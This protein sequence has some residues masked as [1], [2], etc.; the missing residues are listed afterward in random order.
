MQKSKN[1][2]TVQK[3]REAEKHQEQRYRI[4]KWLW[5]ARFFKTR[6]LAQTAVEGGKIH[7]NGGRAKPSKDVHLNDAVTITKGHITFDVIV[8]GLSQRRGSASDAV[9]LY[10]ETE[11]SQ[12]KR[13]QQTA[14]RRIERS[15]QPKFDHRPNKQ[16]R[17]KLAKFRKWKPEE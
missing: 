4:D 11:E 14:Q 10:Q 3:A 16:E 2:K 5:A 1:S 17:R 8:K 15:A 12:L 6:S 13:E 7:L 9:L